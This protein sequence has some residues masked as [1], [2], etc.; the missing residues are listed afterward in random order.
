MD[1]D[2]VRDMVKANFG[3][4]RID[5]TN[6]TVIGAGGGNFIADRNGIARVWMDHALWPLMTA[7]LY[8]DQ[9]GDI[10]ILNVPAPYFKDPQAMR[11]KKIDERWDNDCENQQRTETGVLYQGSILEHLLIQHLTAF[12]EAGG[13]NIF[14]LRGADWNDAMDIASEN[15]ENVAFT[16]AYA[17]NLCQLAQK[18]GQGTVELLEELQE[19]LADDPGVYADVRQKNKLLDQYAQRCR[20]S[21]FHIP[22]GCGGQ[23]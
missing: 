19:L 8:I 12:Y 2:S 18:S 13:H 16:C 4:V 3:G 15:G 1:P 7:K 6:A 5:G 23:P 22:F 21:G 9:T 11:G 10:E 17:G 20:H 14:R